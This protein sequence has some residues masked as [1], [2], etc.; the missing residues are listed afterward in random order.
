M[1]EM[2]GQCNE[3]VKFLQM[4]SFLHDNILKSASKIVVAEVVDRPRTCRQYNRKILPTE[5]INI[6]NLMH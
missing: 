6:E 1:T 4:I 2:V 5:V 3:V